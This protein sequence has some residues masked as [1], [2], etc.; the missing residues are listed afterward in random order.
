DVVAGLSAVAELDRAPVD[1][2][3]ARQ[4]QLLGLAPTGQAGTREQLLQPFARAAGAFVLATGHR[5]SLT[6]W[7]SGLLASTRVRLRMVIGRMLLVVRLRL[8]S[9]RAVSSAR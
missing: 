4:D 8:R 2:D 9:P 5:G 3:A 7:L 1:A 6:S